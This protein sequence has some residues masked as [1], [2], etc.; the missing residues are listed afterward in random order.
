MFCNKHFVPNSILIFPCG[1]QIVGPP[2]S[3]ATQVHCF[4]VGGVLD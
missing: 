4:G 2:G 3:G 1:L